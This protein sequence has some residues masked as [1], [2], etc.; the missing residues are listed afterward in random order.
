MCDQSGNYSTLSNYSSNASG[1]PFYPGLTQN[2]AGGVYIVPTW[3]G[4][5]N[6]SLSRGLPY[7]GSPYFKY[8][9]A[10]GVNGC[11]GCPVSYSQVF[12]NNN[13]QP[14]YPY[15]NSPSSYPYTNP[16]VF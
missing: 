6:T 14:S 8:G 11:N 5:S 9:L 4:L 7:D 13:N 1:S 10:Y 15:N 12:C 2:T 3:T 16:P